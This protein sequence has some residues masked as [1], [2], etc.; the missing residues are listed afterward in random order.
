MVGEIEI[1][2]LGPLL[3]VLL[4]IVII[5]F[6]LKLGKKVIV[7]VIN[8][9]IGL[10]VLALLNLLPFVDVQITIWSILIAGLGGIPGIILLL[11]LDYLDLAF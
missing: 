2:F 8:S 11:L 10:V 7:V 6:V 5:Y 1:P 4:A 3:V 9:F